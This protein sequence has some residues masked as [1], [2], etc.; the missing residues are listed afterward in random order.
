MIDRLGRTISIYDGPSGEL[1]TVWFENGREYRYYKYVL[2]GQQPACHD[3][4]TLIGTYLLEFFY[5]ISNDLILN[6]YSSEKAA[7]CS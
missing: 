3:A 1:R 5:S 4:L 6:E 7:I 2:V